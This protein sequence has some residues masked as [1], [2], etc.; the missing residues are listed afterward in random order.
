MAA[1]NAEVQPVSRS[2]VQAKPTASYA[3]M[4]FGDQRLNTLAKNNRDHA[5]PDWVSHYLLDD[6]P[7]GKRKFFKIEGCSNEVPAIRCVTEN[8]V[9]F[10]HKKSHHLPRE[11]NAHNKSVYIKQFR[12]Q[13]EYEPSILNSEYFDRKRPN[14]KYVR[15][16]DWRNDLLSQVPKDAKFGTPEMKFLDPTACLEEF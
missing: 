10:M 4:D 3:D 11:K 12:S 7:Y 14:L 5:D 9:M 1:N 15:F 16:S 8:A 6:R 13:I 2:W